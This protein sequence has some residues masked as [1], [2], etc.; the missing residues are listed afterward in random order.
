MEL[1]ERLERIKKVN[2]EKKAEKA[3]LEG[4]LESLKEQMKKDF[5]CDTIEELEEKG[6]QLDKEIAEQ[7]PIL[8]AKLLEM[9]E[10]LGIV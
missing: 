1:Q 2:E 10:K 5:G 3:R 6:R 9:E 4:K 8:E 7:R